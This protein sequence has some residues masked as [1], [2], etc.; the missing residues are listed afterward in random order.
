VAVILWIL[1]TWEVY[2]MKNPDCFAANVCGELR[3]WNTEFRDVLLPKEI[4]MSSTINPFGGHQGY[5]RLPDDEEPEKASAVQ[6]AGE[7]DAERPSESATPVASSSAQPDDSGQTPIW[8]RRLLSTAW[9]KRRSEAGPESDPKPLPPLPGIDTTPPNR[10]LRG[11]PVQAP[12]FI[13]L[14]DRSQGSLESGQDSPPRQIDDSVETSPELLAQA[15][16]TPFDHLPANATGEQFSRATTEQIYRDALKD[17]A[18]KNKREGKSFPKI[19]AKFA[20]HTQG[21]SLSPEGVVKNLINRELAARAKEDTPPHSP[22]SPQQ[23]RNLRLKGLGELKQYR[24][25]LQTDVEQDGT[26]LQT[27]PQ[28]GSGAEEMPST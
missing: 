7:K 25:G 4:R 21:L 28:S 23:N 10:A 9:G 2:A 14:R 19:R 5:E 13:P 8:R 15:S 24:T 22:D 20:L 18:A 3:G 12:R 17:V 6:S 11:K 1:K 26:G 27:D 16:P